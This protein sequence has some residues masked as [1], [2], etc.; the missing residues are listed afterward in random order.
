MSLNYKNLNNSHKIEQR[1]IDQIIEDPEGRVIL[2]FRS[3]SI[4]EEP[5]SPG[6]S[7][8]RRSFS[9]FSSKSEPL[10]HPQ[11][12]RFQAPIPEP[13]LDPLSPTSSGIGVAI[14]VL[15]HLVLPSIGQP[16]RKIIILTKMLPYVHGLNKLTE[17]LKK[18]SKRNGLPT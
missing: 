11:R 1:E 18:K 6:P 9:E 4:R 5:I 8:F 10:D 7:N 14:N 3:R 15:P 2:K 17:T 16:L 12:Y 13:V